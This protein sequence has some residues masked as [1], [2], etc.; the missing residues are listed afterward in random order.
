MSVFRPPFCPNP[1]CVSHIDPLSSQSHS[2]SHTRWYKRNG[3]YPTKVRGPVQLFKCLHCGRGFSTQTFSIDYYVKR[4]ITYN[5]IESEIISCSSIRAASRSIGCSCDSVSNRISRLARQ[6]ISLHAR[7]LQC[8]EACENF[9]ADGFESYAVSQYHPNNIHI[10][11][12]ASSQ[13]VY[14]CDYI[15]LR[16]SGRMRDVQKRIRQALES[17]YC[18]PPQALLHSFAEL[19]HTLADL[20]SRSHQEHTWLHTDK[21]R[22]YRRALKQNEELMIAQAHNR[23]SHQCTSSRA[24]R[25]AANPLFAV[26][27]IDREFRKDLAEH[28]RETVRFARNVNHSMERLWVYLMHHNFTKRYRINDPVGVERRHSTEAGVNEQAARWAQQKI[29]KMRRFV[30]F[31]QMNESMQRV[32]YRR[33]E[34]P[35]RTAAKGLVRKIKAAAMKGPV[36]IEE[37]MKRMGI[38]EM[39]VDRRQYLPKYALM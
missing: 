39:T 17:I 10:L 38:T 1:S 27:Y 12:G 22:E 24:A 29:W 15:T 30:S 23:F 20:L 6:S 32:W 31:E 21:K 35:L 4:S 25:T 7:V 34:T 13:F 11:V 37:V 3:T 9:V 16:R 8:I 5:R 28:V 14:H 19:L 18:P 2:L 33:H 26:N 36:D